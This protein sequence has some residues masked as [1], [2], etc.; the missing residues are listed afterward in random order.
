MIR[1]AFSL[2]SGF[3]AAIALVITAG[4]GAAFAAQPQPWQLNFQE[5]ASEIMTRITG[6]G[7]YTL[8]IITIIT[9]FVL[10]LLIIV[11]VRFNASANPNPSRVSHNTT[12]EIVWTVVPILIIVAIAIPSFRLLFD[13]MTIPEADVT[14]K[15]TGYQWYWGY[16]YPDHGET[17]FDSFMLGSPEARQARAEEM[18]QDISEYP[19]LLAVDADMVVPVN[20]NVVVQVTAADVMHSFALPAFGVK[21]DAIPGRL[22]ET[23]FKAERTGLYYGQC[24]ELCGKDHAY[25]PIAIRVVTDEQFEAWIA[26]AADDVEEANRILAGLLESE[27]KIALNTQ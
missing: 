13:E 24:S 10:A 19:R 18:G 6:F 17:G 26:A 25:M 15:V 1:Q 2:I 27:D 8:T 4:T 20:K 12:L 22:N 5:S 21:I 16:E 3:F 9:L 7:N 14:V 23:W 11:A